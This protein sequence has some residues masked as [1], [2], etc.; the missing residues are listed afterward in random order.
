MREI[1]PQAAA[2]DQTALDAAAKAL[3]AHAIKGVAGS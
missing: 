2:P 1:L 3:K